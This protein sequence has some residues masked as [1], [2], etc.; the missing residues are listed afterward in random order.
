MLVVHKIGLR[1]A[2][3]YLDERCQG[4]WAGAG[5]ADLGLGGRVERPALVAAL[6]GCDLDG[7][8][9]LGRRSPRRRAGF[10]LIFGAPK[11]VSLLAGLTGGLDGPSDRLT[12]P[13]VRPGRWPDMATLGAV[14]VAAHDA[15]VC[16]TLGYLE[17]RA[18]WTRRGSTHTR[19]PTSG[20]IAAGFRHGFSWS[21]DP[22]LHTHVV[23]ANLV[24]GADATWSCLDSRSV[25]NHRRAATAVY[26]ASLRHQ[27]DRAGF[28]LGWTVRPDGLAD[29]VGVPR[30]A[31]EACSSRR[32]AILEDDDGFMPPTEAARRAAAGRTRR[33][34]QRPTDSWEA[35][36][37][38]SG[39]DGNLAA[40][41]L[42]PS[43]SARGDVTIPDG[44]EV[45]IDGRISATM[46]SFE[47]SD[48]VRLAA[49]HLP[50]GAPA[51]VIET[52]ATRFMDHA[53]REDDRRSV[54]PLLRQR[55]QQLADLVTRLSTR[56]GLA[57]PATIA[58]ALAD[59]PGLDEVARL[60]VE[61]LTSS[62][63]CVE[64]LGYGPFLAQAAVIEAAHE[65]WAASGHRVAVIA[66][67]DRA[68]SR[69]RA[70]AGLEAPPALPRHASVIII[71]N[72]DR[73]CTAA[74]HSVVA[75]GTSRQAKIVLVEGG[76]GP[77]PRPR[78]E[79]AYAR[80]ASAP[81]GGGPRIRQRASPGVSAGP[82][83]SGRLR[84]RGHE[85]SRCV[86]CRRR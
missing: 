33:H 52:W 21:G 60:A 28:A 85:D 75:D 51:E 25:Y 18:T 13:F 43:T 31:I 79:P 66:P 59:R 2:D 36:A 24:L 9:L 17:R 19:I 53:V 14:I 7:R 5:C 69:W 70:V 44:L 37:A 6:S 16:D 1:Q 12:A 55:G 80:V 29:I 57:R 26:Q 30:T 73:L 56:T 41:L 76:T 11:S 82:R 48:C 39:L 32:L 81:S 62:G 63:A 42:G 64:R 45:I 15:A 61:T 54:T 72:A 77:A 3:Y 65:A 71:D 34:H 40:S 50:Q 67:T 4:R 68:R 58:R 47:H 10:D 78:A 35:R 38:A 74:L 84:G 20:L 86:K 49:A 23:V 46:S 83:R 22:H 8:L 27:L